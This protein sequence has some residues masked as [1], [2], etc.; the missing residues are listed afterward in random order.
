MKLVKTEFWWMN[1][2]LCVVL[3]LYCM[4]FYMVINVYSQVFTGNIREATT[5]TQNSVPERQSVDPLRIG[6]PRRPG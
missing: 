3:V 4:Y 5:Q 2:K 1:E 6:E